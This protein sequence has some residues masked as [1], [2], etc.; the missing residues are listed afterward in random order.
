[1][2]SGG[3]SVY[4]NLLNSF[5]DKSNSLV[6]LDVRA[7]NKL[8]EFKKAKVLFLNRGPFR[9]LRVFLIR[10]KYLIKFSSR[11]INYKN[12]KKFSEIFLNGWPPFFRFPSNFCKLY[13]LCINKKLFEQL[14][15]FN[16][17]IYNF[18]YIFYHKIIFNLFLKKNDILIAQTKTM[19]KLLSNLYSNNKVIL[20]DQLW[21]SF[22]ID[23]FKFLQSNK[24]SSKINNAKSI[25]K[26]NITFFYPA[27]YQPHKNHFNLINGFELLNQFKVAN[28]KLIL[29]IDES[30]I[31]GYKN[32]NLDNILCL[33]SLQHHEIFYLYSFFDYLIFPSLSESYGLPLLEAKINNLKIIASDL[34][35]VYDICNPDAV[36]NPLDSKDICNTLYSILKN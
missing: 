3:G 22:K 2:H 26:K 4:I 33:G 20:Q 7:K 35:Y 18:L 8:S 9:N 23:N 32:I 31:V 34:D 6:V 30:S 36:F 19:N 12:K 5:I 16:F 15:L 24:F 28:Y 14:D 11:R 27:Y 10:L 17:N 21:S 1:M 29:T 25:S 13:I